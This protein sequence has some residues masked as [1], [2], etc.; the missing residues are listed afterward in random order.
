MGDRSGEGITL[1]N[2]G[3]FYFDQGRYNVALACFLLA[4]NI[5]EEVQS[6]N[7]DEIQGWIDDLNQKVGEAQF[8]TLLS[9]VE[10]QAQ[11][12]VEQTLHE[13]LGQV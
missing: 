4:R 6:P 8:V 2:I 5:F 12:I 11:Q 7:R 9:Q 3:A 10:P 13:G 1:W